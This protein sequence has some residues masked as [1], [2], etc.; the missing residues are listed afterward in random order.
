MTSTDEPGSDTSGSAQRG[1]YI[2][3]AVLTVAEPS[4]DRRQEPRRVL[5]PGAADALTLLAE[6]HDVV[7]IAEA[8]VDVAEVAALPT[9]TSVPESFAPGSWFVTA[10]ETWCEGDRPT[11]LRSI[12]VGP[13]R[14]PA[15]RPTAR[16][17]LEARDLN[18]AVMEILVR[19]TMA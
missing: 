17:D 15:K 5:A 10:D 12:L 16:C 4:P 11:G 19:E 6:G 1:V 8:P 13:K 3:V 2:D 7:V 9:A 14:P 18:A